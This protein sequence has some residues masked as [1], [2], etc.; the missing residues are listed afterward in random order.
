MS[1]ECP[2]Q[3]GHPSDSCAVFKERENVLAA[4]VEEIAV[5][6][7]LTSYK[8]RMGEELV[9]SMLLVIDC[10]SLPQKTLG[11]PTMHRA[12]ANKVTTVVMMQVS[13]ATGAAEPLAWEAQS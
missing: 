4:W 2:T 10:S 9:S 11:P 7:V 6:R 8:I 5:S 3:N 12:P 13:C 1:S